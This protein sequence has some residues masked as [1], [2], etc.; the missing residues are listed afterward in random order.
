[1]LTTIQNLELCRLVYE[2]L[3][4]AVGDDK[5]DNVVE[6]VKNFGSKPEYAAL[7]TMAD[8]VLLN[9]SHSSDFADG[10]SGAAFRNNNTGEIVFSFRGTNDALDWGFS[11]IPIALGL[12][13]RQY[14]NA[15]RFVYQTLYEQANI[16]FASE[17][18]ML[19]LL[20]TTANA[21]FTGHSLGG[22]L[23]QYLTFRTA[24]P[25]TGN[26]GVPSETFNSVGI[27]QSLDIRE[28]L[29]CGS[30]YNVTDHVDSRDFVGDYGIQL[31]TTIHH[32]DKN[33]LDYAQVDFKQ[34]GEM[35]KVDVL[36]Q[37]GEISY[38]EAESTKSRILASLSQDQ[39]LATQSIYN[40][41]RKTGGSGFDIEHYHG[42]DR[43]INSD[44]SLV[45]A[46]SAQD[47]IAESSSCGGL[48][49]AIN[50]L[51]VIETAKREGNYNSALNG[52]LFYD[53]SNVYTLNNIYYY[54]YSLV[55]GSPVKYTYDPSAIRFAVTQLNGMKRGIQT[56]ALSR[57]CIDY[58]SAQIAGS[59]RIDPLVLDLN[60]DG[61]KTVSLAE[62]KAYFD[63][64]RDGKLLKNRA[65]EY[66]KNILFMLAPKGIVRV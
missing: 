20:N 33:D 34:I 36:L 35:L 16:K 7:K 22:G 42:L 53:V 52:T 29:T 32:V 11:N 4:D 49:N 15:I 60:N 63:L 9:T 5:T 38:A 41:Y 24:D 54:N 25:A 13:A 1:M 59:R 23:A 12:I 14:T 18:N 65:E 8:W 30:Q 48:F 46:V 17:S 43:F 31:G 44:G 40:G 58:Q 6:I 62:S 51:R 56:G 45:R 47:G 10:F 27:G 21:S 26:F 57:Q 61:I 39:R 55:A 64:E 37:S 3:P 2:N 28:L 19:E 50:A 66:L